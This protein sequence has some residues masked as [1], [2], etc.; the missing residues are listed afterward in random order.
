MITGQITTYCVLSTHYGLGAVEG[1][2]P[3][4]MQ[5][6]LLQQKGSWV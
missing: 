3:R 4:N 6:A 2:S 5:L 1:V